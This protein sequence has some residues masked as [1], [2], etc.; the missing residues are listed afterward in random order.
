MTCPDG[1]PLTKQSRGAA[2][3]GITVLSSFVGASWGI[4]E[5][6]LRCW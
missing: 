2:A 1:L 6:K 4:L 5:M 3:L